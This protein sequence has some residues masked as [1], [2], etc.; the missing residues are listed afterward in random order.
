MITPLATA[1]PVEILLQAYTRGM[2]PMAHEDGELYWHEPD[3]R[4]V[5]DLAA[6]QPDPRTAR[7]IRSGRFRTSIDQAFEEVIDACAD[8]EE[9]WIDDRIRASYT[10]LFQAGYA[11]SVESW[12][13]DRLVG[14]IYGVAMGS[15]FFGESMFSRVSNAGKVAFYALVDRLRAQ[16]FTLFDTQ[17]INPFTAQLGAREVPKAVFLGALA[18]ARTQHVLFK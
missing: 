14:G 18:D 8:R 12:E 17:Y 16:G 5:F 7:V 4:A 9:T 2:F 13:G 10:A 6:L 11:H 3:P 1:I 15:A